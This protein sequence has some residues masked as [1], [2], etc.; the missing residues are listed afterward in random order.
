MHRAIH[1]ETTDRPAAA[2]GT[3]ARSPKEYAGPAAA[4]ATNRA[5]R[6]SPKMS[7][8][9]RIRHADESRLRWSP[10][11]MRFYRG[12][13]SEEPAKAGT[14]TRTRSKRMPRREAA[15]EQD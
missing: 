10:A 8:R 6:A 3:P 11:F 7:S 4:S 12:A 5:S 1:Q 14:P 9:Y 13:A 2:R 15:F